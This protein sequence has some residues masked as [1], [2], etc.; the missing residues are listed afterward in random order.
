MHDVVKQEF[1]VLGSLT[2]CSKSPDT[3]QQTLFKL[4]SR[5]L[6]DVKHRGWQCALPCSS[7]PYFSASDLPYFSGKRE[8]KVRLKDSIVRLLGWDLG[9]IS[10]H[11]GTLERH[12]SEVLRTQKINCVIDVGANQGQYGR[13]LRRAGYRGRINSFEPVWE[14]FEVLAQRAEKDD[15]WFV[16]QTALGRRCATASI[17]RTRDSA[18]A[19]FLPPSALAA[20]MFQDGAE[21]CGQ[22]KVPVTRLDEL[23]DVLHRDQPSP[24]IFLKMDTQGYDLEVFAG[25]S[26][27]LEQIHG[28][29]SELSVLPLYEGMPDYIAA[30]REYRR[31]GFEVTGFY[32]VFRS[33]PT[34]VLG[35]IDCVMVR[36]LPSSRSA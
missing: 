17:L 22:E 19:S 23:M 21:V 34:L 7:F 2:C 33:K 9:K 31:Y 27:C 8:H 29:Q 14:N 5:L 24:R 12:L 6:V 11:H 1:R 25:S 16:H 10:W 30:L 28:L 4:L 26:G 36:R 18:L 15:K 3:Y 35:E 13:M 20:T 32:P